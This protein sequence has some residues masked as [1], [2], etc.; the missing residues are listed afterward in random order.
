[1]SQYF[2][3]H[4]NDICGS[5]EIDSETGAF[6]AYKD[7]HTGKSP[8]LGNCDAKH[9]KKWWDSR[10]VPASR[11]MMQEILR[12]SGCPNM[13]SYLA[14][15]LALSM[16]DSY[17]ICPINV[18]INYED[19][20]FQSIASFNDGK[21]PYHNAT[22]YDLNASLGGQMEKY[23]DLNTE[24]PTLVKESYKYYGQQ[25]INEVFATMLH[26]KQNTDIP[27]VKYHAVKTLDNGIICRCNSFTN[28]TIELVPALEVIE[29]S[30]I[31]ND[32]SLYENYIQICA[33]LGISEETIRN[34][35]DYQTL[36]DFVISNTDEHLFNF[37]ILRNVDTFEYIGPAPI[38][39]SGNSMFYAESN[40]ILSRA[41]LLERKIT[42]FYESEEKM[43]KNVQNKDIVDVSLLPK[44]S[45]VIDL[46]MTSGIPEEKATVIAMNYNTKVELVKDFQ[47]GMTISL[48]HEKQK[49]KQERIK[50]N[51]TVTFSMICGIPGSGKTEKA[52]E[53]IDSFVKK[54]YR[55]I[56]A[57]EL[58]PLTDELVNMKYIIGVV[59]P[60]KVIKNQTNERSFTYISANDV[61][62]ELT[63]VKNDDLVF[64]V[65]DKRIK[66]ALD[67]GIS[68]IYEATNLDI[69][70]RQHYIQLAGPIQKALYVMN[71][72]AD[73]VNTNLP[74]KLLEQ[75]EYRLQKD[76]PTKEEG[77]SEIY[78]SGN[79]THVVEVDKK[80]NYDDVTYDDGFDPAEE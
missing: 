64:Y 1:M 22:S 54:G 50:T 46:Y 23:W 18:D 69:S 58:Y 19:I 31:Q 3:M 55:E 29:G 25:A 28:D 72:D 78:E 11:K 26:E 56:E 70:T 42:A 65:I 30:K 34:F 36:T 9:M 74:R 49:Q 73:H 75:K 44:S 16:T 37:G 68:V 8:F 40:I 57:K 21:I 33:K 53:L 4:K 60:H 15:N 2:L 80:E 32:K 52:H 13:E 59:E 66:E 17:W 5:L 79:N 76:F 24:N 67:R 20:Q 7:H 61:R 51:S 38:F 14:K 43:L 6:I 63:D 48:Y 35:M 77:W 12:Q 39:D 62:K 27:F 47:R 71:V 10:A 41:A 45:D